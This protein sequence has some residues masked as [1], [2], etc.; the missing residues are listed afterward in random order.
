MFKQFAIFITIVSIFSLFTYAQ[1]K[2]ET[3]KKEKMECT[4]DSHSCCGSHQMHSDLKTEESNETASALPWN[5]VCPI[6]GEEVDPEAGTVEYNG[7]LYGFCCPGCDSKFLKDPDKY[8]KNL[9]EDGTE[10]IGG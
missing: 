9:N 10:F 3:E 7:K 4:K 2:P 8:S 1:E 5:K 6:K